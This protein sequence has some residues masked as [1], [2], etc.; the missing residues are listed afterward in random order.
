MPPPVRVGSLSVA[1][2]EEI[3]KGLAHFQKQEP[4]NPN[5][6]LTLHLT[7]TTTIHNDYLLHP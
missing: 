7:L 1:D 2:M 3:R 4:L 5:L 6:K